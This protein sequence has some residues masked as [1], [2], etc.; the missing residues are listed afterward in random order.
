VFIDLFSGVTARDREAVGAYRHDG[1]CWRAR[2]T[3]LLALQQKGSLTFPFPSRLI[4]VLVAFPGFEVFRCF[5]NTLAADRAA[6]PGAP[7][8][9]PTQRETILTS[10]SLIIPALT[11]HLR[12]FEEV[13]A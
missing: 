11:P 10:E 9:R 2:S 13:V 3:R 1:V 7:P 4:A 6:S 8:P 12:M 5:A